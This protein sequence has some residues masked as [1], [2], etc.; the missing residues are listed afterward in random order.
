MGIW[1]YGY[2]DIWINGYMD[3]W[4]VTGTARTQRRNHIKWEA[5]CPELPP[6]RC[7]A[8]DHS[9][10]RPCLFKATYFHLRDG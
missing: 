5:I 1:I 2:M 4:T 8:P 6:L 9:H 7:H 10:A 3:I